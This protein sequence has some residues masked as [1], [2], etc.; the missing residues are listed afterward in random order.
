MWTF[1]NNKQ[2]VKRILQKT[3][4]L[5]RKIQFNY[6]DQLDLVY[7]HYPQTAILCA[8]CHYTQIFVDVNLIYVGIAKIFFN[9]VDF[10]VSESPLY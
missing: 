9:E 1:T 10:F 3:K 5:N 7:A 8:Y 2:I 4:V 6:S